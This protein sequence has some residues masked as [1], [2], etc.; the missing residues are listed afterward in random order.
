MK[1]N[2]K[3]S[4]VL[5]FIPNV[6]TAIFSIISLPFLTEKLSLSDFGYFFLCSILVNL[7]GI[8]TSFGASFSMA[9]YFYGKKLQIKKFLFLQYFF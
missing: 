7:F 5:F 3:L 1:D 4:A 2:V 9:R 8:F 6:V